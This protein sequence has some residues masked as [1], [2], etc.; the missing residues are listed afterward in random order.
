[1]LL[2][3]HVTISLCCYVTMLLYHYVAKSPFYVSLCF[4]FI[5][6]LF[7]ICCVL[8]LILVTPF[9]KMHYVL[10]LF[11][12]K[13]IHF[14][15]LLTFAYLVFHFKKV[16]FWEFLSFFVCPFIYTTLTVYDRSF[17]TRLQPKY[18]YETPSH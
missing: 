2:C 5:V 16:I 11:L 1:M 13:Q 4:D 7:I 15:C 14:L 6:L 9:V 3:H 18:K 12:D 8:Q 10:F 17:I